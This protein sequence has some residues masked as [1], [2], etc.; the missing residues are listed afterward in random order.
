M[1]IVS[2]KS[3]EY[4]KTLVN[5]GYFWDQEKNSYVDFLVVLIKNADKNGILI[6][7]KIF[8]LLL[9]QLKWSR[10]LSQQFLERL[11]KSGHLSTKGKAIYLNPKYLAIR[12]CDGIFVISEKK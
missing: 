10:K 3:D 1:K 12:D 7:K 6:R 9:D 2:V 11:Q 8:P 4:L 5:V